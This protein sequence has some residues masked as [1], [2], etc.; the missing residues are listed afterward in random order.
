[1]AILA[2]NAKFDEEFEAEKQAAGTKV[3]RIFTNTVSLMRAAAESL[4]LRYEKIWDGKHDIHTIGE[5]KAKSTA[6]LYELIRSEIQKR[7][8]RG[9]LK[10]A[11]SAKYNLPMF[12]IV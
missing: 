12:K 8:D 10:S 4:N 9:V 7:G 5:Y 3:E 6:A 11:R 1:M 2:E